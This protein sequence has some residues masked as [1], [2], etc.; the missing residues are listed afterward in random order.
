VPAG[1][2][3]EAPSPD[4]PVTLAALEQRGVALTT[5]QAGVVTAADG[6][7]AQPPLT[8]E[9]LPL[10]TKLPALVE[11]NLAEAAI[12]DAGL[13]ALKDLPRLK[14]LGLRRC[15]QITDAGLAHLEH[16]PN[17]ERLFLLFTFI[18]N[19]GMEHVAKLKKLKVLDL[20]GSKVSDEGLEKLR[21]HP[22]L[23]D[24]SV[25]TASMTDTAVSH[26]ATIKQLRY[27]A[28]EDAYVTEAALPELGTLTGLQK[29]HLMRTYISVDDEALAHLS[30]LTKLRDLRLRGNAAGVAFLSH[31]KGSAGSLA[32]LDLSECPINDESALEHLVAFQK[33]ET[34]ELWQTPLSDIGLEYVGQLPALRKLDISKC[35]AITSAGLEHV[36]GLGN[37]EQLDLSES[38]IGDAGLER[39]R[40]CKS[41][42]SLTLKQV[43]VSPEAVAA[44]QAAVPECKIVR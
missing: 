3:A 40:G 44:F 42:R 39:L 17:L 12:T 30:G 37:L 33:L 4:D 31:V 43:A 19:G 7:T 15:N 13:A 20:R 6:T 29:L 38:K 27:L 23:V 18:G 36:V 11:L 26:I 1:A 2:P 32:H 22:A 21:E 9:D 24:L 35:P 25:R 16:V 41:L 14:V 8:D 28:I 34:L 10:F 5:S